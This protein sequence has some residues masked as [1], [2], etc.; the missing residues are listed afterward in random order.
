MKSFV[1]PQLLYE[2]GPEYN[3]I[4]YDSCGLTYYF[5]NRGIKQSGLSRSQPMVIV[6]VSDRYGN[7]IRYERDEN[8]LVVNKIIDTYGR[9]V[10]I[11]RS[12][13]SYYDKEKD[14]LKT[15][16][17]NYSQ[18]PASALENDSYL[19]E[20][21]VLRLTV[22]NEIGEQT[23]YDAREVEIMCHYESTS[24]SRDITE[25]TDPQDQRYEFI[26]NYNIEQITYPDNSQVN[27]KYKPYYIQNGHIRMG[28]YAVEESYLKKD[29][30]I[31]NRKTYSLSGDAVPQ[32]IEETDLSRGSKTVNT[33]I[34]GLLETSTK[35][36]EHGSGR[37]Y[38]LRRYDGYNHLRNEYK[39]NNGA[40]TDEYYSY[41]TGYPDSL[42]YVYDNKQR[43]DYTY[44]TIDGDLTDIPKTIT[45]S[46]KNGRSW[47]IDYIITTTLTSDKK[48]IEYQ[49]VTKAGETKAK[50]KYS[51]NESGE[52]TE[53]KYWT[54][55]TNSDGLF[56]EADE[57]ITINNSYTVTGNDALR[58]CQSIGGIVDADGNSISDIAEIYEYDIYG[59]PTAQT[60]AKNYKT[61]IIYIRTVHNRILN[62]T[63]N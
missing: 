15:I 41:A 29:S 33:Y 61:E 49:T 13:I 36:E 50:T 45:Y 55:D 27:F 9:E 56:D 63:M 24:T 59:N 62:I 39:N 42:E 19:S 60:D 6:A 34:D 1:R 20:K 5:Y 30:Q 46:Y 43:I 51:Y 48:S 32:E 10:N 22:T 8:S 53:I 54:G 26:N 16:S 21:P 58:I 31:K 11:S 23:I 18:L 40:V 57:T 37:I 38:I 35:D 4:V 25:I 52:I 3:F 7:M 47:K 12:G 28:T 17:Y 44:H 14:E 2:N